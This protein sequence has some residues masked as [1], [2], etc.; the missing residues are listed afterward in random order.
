[1]RHSRR[2]M[3]GS[4]SVMSGFT[5]PSEITED[6][7]CVWAWRQDIQDIVPTRGK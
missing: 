5:F 3:I 7:A 4:I 1:M 6:L 2:Q